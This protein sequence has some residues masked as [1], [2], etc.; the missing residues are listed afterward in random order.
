MNSDS[1]H[2]PSPRDQKTTPH[3]VVRGP[4]KLLASLEKELHRVLCPALPAAVPEVSPPSLTKG[5]SLAYWAP[6]CSSHRLGSCGLLDHLLNSPGAWPESV[7]WMKE[8]L[9]RLQVQ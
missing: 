3:T 9:G 6:A 1:E 7:D 8:V 5:S 2:G 4:R